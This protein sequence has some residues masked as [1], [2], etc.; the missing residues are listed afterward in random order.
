MDSKRDFFFL[1]GEGNNGD[2]IEQEKIYGQFW[3]Y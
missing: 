1:V 2:G 3:E